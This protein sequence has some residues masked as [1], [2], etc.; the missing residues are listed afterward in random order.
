MTYVY[1]FDDDND[2]DDSEF[3]EHQHPPKMVR[4][5]CFICLCVIYATR[6]LKWSYH[7]FWSC[8]V[9]LR[10]LALKFVLEA[11]HSEQTRREPEAL[12]ARW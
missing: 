11:R 8:D 5:A 3:G 9:A 7:Y 10:A 4:L 12:E 1:T 6:F 2:D